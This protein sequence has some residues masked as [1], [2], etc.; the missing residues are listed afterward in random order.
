MVKAMNKATAAAVGVEAAASEM[1]DADDTSAGE[2]KAA[3][4][5]EPEK[6]KPA[7]DDDLGWIDD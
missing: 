7:A 1:V 3:E 6:P 2:A 4:Q 5:S